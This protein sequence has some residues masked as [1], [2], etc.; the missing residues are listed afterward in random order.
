MKHKMVQYIPVEPDDW[1]KELDK[2]KRVMTSDEIAE[3]T[4]KAEA[5]DTEA[6]DILGLC[7][8]RGNGV[9]RDVEKAVYWYTKAS[10]L[11]HAAA[12]LKLALCYSGDINAW[13]IGTDPSRAVYWLEKSAMQGNACAQYNL[14]VC[15][16]EGFGVEKNAKKAVELFQIAADAEYLPAQYNLGVCY[17]YG[18]GVEPD[19]EI[20]Q[21]WNERYYSSKK[22][23]LRNLDILRVEDIY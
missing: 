21:Y 12:Q 4:L 8:F 14:G 10:E 6:Q 3:I 18:I 9:T 17:K 19:D 23:E 22:P 13:K 2:N 5:G 20:A 15:Y 16:I 1:E 11:G 7:Y